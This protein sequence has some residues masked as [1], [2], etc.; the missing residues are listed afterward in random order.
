MIRNERQYWIVRSEVKRFE[1]MLDESKEDHGDVH[2]LLVKV[3]QD[4]TNSQLAE[5]KADLQEYE[6]L[7]S[8]RFDFSELMVA[9]RLPEILIKARIARGL[10]QQ[11]LAERIGLKVQQIQR[12]EATD[13]ASA[14]LGRIH[15]VIGGLMVMVENDPLTS[16]EFRKGKLFSFLKATFPQSSSLKDYR[17]EVRPNASIYM[18]KSE[19]ESGVEVARIRQICVRH[20]PNAKQLQSYINR[21]G[22]ES[23]SPGRDYLISPEH[24]DPVVAILKGK[25]KSTGVAVRQTLQ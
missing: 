17:F 10:T 20:F 5:L 1:Q 9:I 18:R 24:I 21:N 4:A 22:I 13:Y 8:G 12:Y 11:E 14:S 19:L 25:T 15:D 6:A 23:D 3:R 7:K 16:R 2:P